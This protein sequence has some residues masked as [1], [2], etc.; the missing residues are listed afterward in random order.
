MASQTSPEKRNQINVHDEK[1]LKSQKHKQIGDNVRKSV[2]I[3]IPPLAS[4]DVGITEHDKSG[5]LLLQT[6]R[7]EGDILKKEVETKQ[8]VSVYT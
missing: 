1:E 8:V 2:D 7:E 3:P 6:L 4:D 5:Y